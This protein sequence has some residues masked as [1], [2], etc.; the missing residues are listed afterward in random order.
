MTNSATVTVTVS[1]LVMRISRFRITTGTKYR[2]IGI[3]PADTHLPTA[4]IRRP[5]RLVACA[6]SLT[7]S[8]QSCKS[9]AWKDTAIIVTWDD[10]GG[11]YDHVAPPNVDTYGYGPRVPALIISPYDAP[12]KHHENQF[13]SSAMTRS[14]G[15]PSMSCNGK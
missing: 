4:N 11:F 15:L 6:T 2:T 7:L 13:H 5:T 1:T 12:G 10:Y 8:M 14:T 3:T 9:S